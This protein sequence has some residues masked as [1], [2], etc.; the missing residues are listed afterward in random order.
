MNNKKINFAKNLRTLRTLRGMTQQ[1]LA[2]KIH[3][4]RQTLSTWERGAGKPDIYSVSD[5]CEF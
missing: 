4:T 2:D 1:E 3:I 5:L